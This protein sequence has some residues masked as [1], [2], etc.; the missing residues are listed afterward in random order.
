MYQVFK[1]SQK[2]LKNERRNS[3][4]VFAHICA[5]RLPFINESFEDGKGLY[6]VTLK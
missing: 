4:S 3:D 2:R 6:P 1:A 5:G